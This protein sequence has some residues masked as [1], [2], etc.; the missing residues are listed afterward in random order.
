MQAIQG[1]HS[2]LERGAQGSF[3]HAEDVTGSTLYRGKQEETFS[4]V[5]SVFRGPLLP[6]PKIQTGRSIY[7]LVQLCLGLNRHRELAWKLNHDLKHH[8]FWEV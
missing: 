7:T 8:F 4:Y 2:D 3:A 5:P 1:S 6:G